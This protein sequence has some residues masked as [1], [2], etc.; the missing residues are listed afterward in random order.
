MCSVQ[1]YH[2][3]IRT[4]L[5]LLHPGGPGQTSPLGNKTLSWQLFLKNNFFQLR[6]PSQ[7]ATFPTNPASQQYQLLPTSQ[8]IGEIVVVN[9]FLCPPV[10]TMSNWGPIVSEG[11]GDSQQAVSADHSTQ[12]AAESIPPGRDLMYDYVC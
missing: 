3:L 9:H 6:L 5:P 1:Q 8:S 7:P 11:G 10:S 4:C 2:L 12:P